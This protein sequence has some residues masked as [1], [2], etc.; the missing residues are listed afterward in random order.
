MHGNMVA[1]ISTTTGLDRLFSAFG[2]LK[3]VNYPI[4]LF[5]L[6]ITLEF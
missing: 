1:E 5:F 2:Y 4:P 6:L 3:L